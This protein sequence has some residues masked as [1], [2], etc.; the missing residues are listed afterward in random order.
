MNGRNYNCEK[1]LSIHIIKTSYFYML[2]E[3]M[4]TKKMKIN[5]VK[6]NVK[7]MKFMNNKDGVAVMS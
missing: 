1:I 2:K 4:Y 3:L 7:N 5:H 6:E